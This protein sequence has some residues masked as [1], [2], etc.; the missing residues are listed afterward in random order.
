[1]I[2][3]DSQSGYSYHQQ[4]KQILGGCLRNKKVKQSFSRHSVSKI[5]SSVWW[6]AVQTA[7]CSVLCCKVDMNDIK[8]AIREGSSAEIKLLRTWDAITEN[9]DGL[10]PSDYNGT[11]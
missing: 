5:A 3:M 1:M 6:R 11:T 8:N 2:V 7:K 9:T 4:D 10:L